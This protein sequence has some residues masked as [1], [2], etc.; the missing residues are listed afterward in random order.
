[1]IEPGEVM[2][3]QVSLGNVDSLIL[4][5]EY[6]AGSVPRDVRLASAFRMGRA[7]IRWDWE[8]GSPLERPGPYLWKK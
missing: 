2:T 8:C 7:M 3:W 6:D 4:H 5:G 1:M